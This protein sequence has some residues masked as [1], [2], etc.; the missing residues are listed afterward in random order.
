MPADSTVLWRPV[1][2]EEP[3]LIKKSGMKRF[4]SRLPEQPIFYPVLN[5]EYAT[6]IAR[7]WNA[8]R[9]GGFV[10]R[11]SVKKNFL[12]SYS[13]MTAGGHEHR[14]YRIPSE[15]LEVFNDAVTG[16][17]VVEAEF[18][19]PIMSDTEFQDNGQ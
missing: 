12:S 17:I 10:L 14:E 3:A 18:L 19:F 2:P 16:D 7:E 5:R 13:I 9:G 6:R 8:P 11:F 4:P 1:G 15:H